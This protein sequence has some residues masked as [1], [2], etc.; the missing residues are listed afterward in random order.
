[1]I[2]TKGNVIKIRGGIK[3]VEYTSITF[4]VTISGDVVGG[5][6]YNESNFPLYPFFQEGISG[7]VKTY[8]NKAY[9]YDSFNKRW[10]KLELQ[11]F[12]V[13]GTK[14]QIQQSGNQFYKFT[15]IDTLNPA[16]N[17]QSVSEMQALT[18]PFGK[19]ITL[20]VDGF[21]AAIGDDNKRREGIVYV[22]DSNGEIAQGSVYSWNSI[23]Y[24]WDAVVD[25]IGLSFTDQ[26]NQNIISEVNG[27]INDK[28]EG[29]IKEL[30]STDQLKQYLTR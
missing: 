18:F 4:E 3:I 10:Q 29:P 26:N 25:Y 16:W 20:W 17:I 19:D 22:K 5:S 12:G 23:E 8:S 21:G 13:I 27:F 7:E 30:T 2:I 15:G 9:K 6:Y 1:M 28:L 14:N 24:K 11:P